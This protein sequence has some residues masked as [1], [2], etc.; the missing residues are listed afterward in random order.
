MP[1][2]LKAAMRGR[3]R[4]YRGE[5]VDVVDLA[6]EAAIEDPVTESSGG[7]SAPAKRSRRSVS[8]PRAI[9]TSSS[10]SGQDG[11]GTGFNRGVLSRPRSVMVDG[12]GSGTAPGGASSASGSVGAGGA[13]SAEEVE[14]FKSLLLRVLAKL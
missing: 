10:S 8:R 1:E 11:P 12:R 9:A 5:V 6:A 2:D 7:G 13:L 4:L 14:L 3:A